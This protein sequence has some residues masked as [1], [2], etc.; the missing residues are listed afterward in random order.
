MFE[1]SNCTIFPSRCVTWCN[2]TRNY[3]C[4]CPRETLK[5]QREQFFV[6]ELPINARNCSMDSQDIRRCPL[7]QCCFHEQCVD[8]SIVPTRILLRSSNLNE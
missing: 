8:C 7:G 2:H 1:T 4:I 6:C 5:I 3:L